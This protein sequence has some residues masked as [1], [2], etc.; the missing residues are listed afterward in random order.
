MFP[1]IILGV[2]LMTLEHHSVPGYLGHNRG[3]GNGVANPVSFADGLLGDGK[4][5]GLISIDQNKIGGQGKTLNSQDHRFQ[6]GPEDIEEIDLLVMDYTEPDAKGFL[7]DVFVKFF[8]FL[9]GYLLRIEKLLTDTFFRKDD[10]RSHDRPGERA[11]SH[12][13]HTGNPLVAL[14][15]VH[16]FEIVHGLGGKRRKK[17]DNHSLQNAK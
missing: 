7:I 16:L 1:K 9:G 15:T 6:S 11:S 5:E 4:M 10:S 8:S 13:I 17:H 2:F 12:L 14:P 3:G